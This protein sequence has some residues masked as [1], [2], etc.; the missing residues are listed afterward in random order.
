MDVR[1][2]TKA[3]LERQLHGFEQEFGMKSVDFFR[4]HRFG[5]V[6]ERVP[7]HERVVW[8]DTC[9]RWHRIASAVKS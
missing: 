7:P 5:D 3:S 4:L 6:P 1:V 9:M 2:A 8:A